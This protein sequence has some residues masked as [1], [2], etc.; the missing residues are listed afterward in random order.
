[1]NFD[2]IAYEIDNIHDT[3]SLELAVVSVYGYLK[4]ESNNL[5]EPIAFGI[6]I[7]TLSNKYCLECLKDVIDND[8]SKDVLRLFIQLSMLWIIALWYKWKES[9]YNAYFVKK[10]KSVLFF[11]RQ[12]LDN[13]DSMSWMLF[14]VLD[15]LYDKSNI[16]YFEIDL[17]WKWL[18]MLDFFNTVQKKANIIWITMLLSLNFDNVLKN[19][20]DVTV[21]IMNSEKSTSLLKALTC[22]YGS[23]NKIYWGMESCRKLWVSFEFNVKNFDNI[24]NYF[25]SKHQKI[26]YKII[27]WVV[28]WIQFYD[29]RTSFYDQLLKKVSNLSW[30]QKKLDKLVHSGLSFYSDEL[31]SNRSS[32]Y[33]DKIYLI[34]TKL[35][36]VCNKINDVSETK[37]KI[38][39]A[40]REFF[41]WINELHII[42]NKFNL[43]DDYS[44]VEDYLR[45]EDDRVEWKGSFLTPLE[46]TNP[47]F[48]KQNLQKIWETI[49]SMMNHEGG[50]IIIWHI[51][52]YS[53][54]LSKEG[55]FERWW[56]Y[57][58]DLGV[59]FT[60]FRSDF[61]LIT[62]EIQDII[63]RDL[64]LDISDFDQFFQIIP[65]TL[66]IKWE[67]ITICK[68]V[69]LKAENYMYSIKE[70][71]YMFLR[72]RVNKRNEQILPIINK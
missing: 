13:N 54:L 29:E 70:G 67:N 66:N 65:V 33:T 42:I 41:I 17:T 59:E 69:V 5:D 19:Q 53:K 47:Q 36:I 39:V 9:N 10:I 32:Q 16:R 61:D 40:I 49:I 58:Y 44:L 30:A 51:E 12:C 11:W 27:N 15:V 2:E 23:I 71:I 56:K 45:E 72:K 64:K 50:V 21:G 34:T 3:K 43:I 6:C 4:D 38:S 55:V 46:N 35:Y 28:S 14:K 68:V 52:N 20:L 31:D 18:V 62:R 48:K 1:M 22:I 24:V 26:N 25:D 8:W 63:K 7:K 60:K 57:F 37:W